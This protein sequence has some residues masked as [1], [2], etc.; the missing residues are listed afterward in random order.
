M[1]HCPGIARYVHLFHGMYRCHADILQPVSQCA[2]MVRQYVLLSIYSMRDSTRRSSVHDARRIMRASNRR[3]H[4]ECPAEAK[5]MTRTARC[6]QAHR[7]GHDAG[8]CGRHEGLGNLEQ[9]P[10]TPAQL[11]PLLAAKFGVE[12]LCYVSRQLYV[13]LLVSAWTST[14]RILERQ[15]RGPSRPSISSCLGSFSRM[16]EH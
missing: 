3:Q 6:V 12:A 14:L 5:A 1:R 7:E 11:L 2:I 13:L 15:C 9:P 4:F 16:L 10:A 8:A